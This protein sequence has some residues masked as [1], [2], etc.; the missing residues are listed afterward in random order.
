MNVYPFITVWLTGVKTIHTAPDVFRTATAKDIQA[1]T[2]LVK[3]EKESNS[4]IWS[5]FY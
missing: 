4:N 5:R 3:K 1:V 2:E